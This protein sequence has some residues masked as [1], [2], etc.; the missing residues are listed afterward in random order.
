MA[1]LTPEYRAARKADPEKSA[2]DK[3]VA[4]VRYLRL[5]ERIK[6]YTNGRYHADPKT[7][8]KRARE[9]LAKIRATPEGRELEQAKHNAMVKAWREKHPERAREHTRTRRGHR[10]KA[11]GF[12]TL[13]QWLAR[14]AFYGWRCRYCRTELTEQTLTLDHVIPLSRGGS[15]WP[16]NCV[17]AC[18]SCNSRKHDQTITE[19]LRGSHAEA[20]Q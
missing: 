10:L 7:A 1:T 19:Y 15:E 8:Y 2:R 20:H 11:P 12:H 5:R 6:A 9:R 14:V 16:A 17:P 3:A 13:E 4:R 18:L